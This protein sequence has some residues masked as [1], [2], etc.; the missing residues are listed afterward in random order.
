MEKHK[1]MT[2]EQ[3]LDVI[4]SMIREAKGNV[5]RN[6]FYFLLWGWVVVIANAG[7][8]ILSQLNYERPQMIWAITIPAWLLSIWKMYARR[9]TPEASTHL[10]RVNGWIWLGYGVS[11]TILLV[12]GKAI[13][14][15]LYPVI[16]LTTALP[17]LATGVILRFRPL[18]IGAITFWVFGIVSFLVSK[19]IQPLVNAFAFAAG[20]LVP[21]YL[22]NNKKE[23]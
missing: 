11:L 21:G 4:T 20:Y 6:A 14:Y 7:V 16:L 2:I 10:G 9:H 17:T 1:S 22:L 19:D 8:Y 13:N 5:Q 3:S 18:V 12:F 23:E 15:Q